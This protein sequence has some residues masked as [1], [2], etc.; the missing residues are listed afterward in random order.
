[1]SNQRKKIAIF[2]RYSKNLSNVVRR[3]E[4]RIPDE[5]YLCPIC[6]APFTIKDLAPNPDNFLTLE[7]TPPKRLGGTA[8]IFT[9]FHCN[10]SHG[11]VDKRFGQHLKVR[12][13][14]F[15][16]QD[17]NVPLK[18]RLGDMELEATAETKQDGTLWFKL[19]PGT[20]MEQLSPLV[21]ANRTFDFQVQSAKICHIKVS[22]LRTAYLKAFAALGYEFI[23]QRRFNIIRKQLLNP[24]ELVLPSYGVL[25]SI[26]MDQAQGIYVVTHPKDFQS[27]LVYFKT[28]RNNGRQE[29]FTAL[30]PLPACDVE[31]FYN[32]LKSLENAAGQHS[33]R[34]TPLP[35]IDIAS[36]E[37][38]G[39]IL[40]LL[41]ELT[42]N[43]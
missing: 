25:G 24:D 32:H 42:A 39:R 30:I 13:F 16:D 6:L 29:K 8:D 33:I 12:S 18:I 37:N 36:P 43:V 23:L 21:I 14:L 5:T 41:Q 15:R 7:H 27:L 1:M 2:T 31:A 40:A 19:P 11:R 9:C 3:Y 20:N 10:H 35:K 38:G 17:V 22:I 4:L 28:K 26:S 34:Y